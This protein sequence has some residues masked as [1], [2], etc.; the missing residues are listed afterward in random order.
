MLISCFSEKGPG[1]ISTGSLLH[2]SSGLVVIKLKHS[3][4]M[5]IMTGNTVTHNTGNVPKTSN[6]PRTEWSSNQAPVSY[7][8]ANH[9]FQFHVSL[10]S[11]IVTI[12]DFYQSV[13]LKK[14]CFVQCLFKLFPIVE[15]LI[16]SIAIHRVQRFPLEI[17]VFWKRLTKCEHD[18]KFSKTEGLL[19]LQ[20][21]LRN[22]ASACF[23]IIGSVWMDQANDWLEF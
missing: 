2:L 19:H 12:L 5:T 17:I 22:R 9:I 23:K 10:T 3:L 4:K 1:Y 15:E 8:V 13:N 6:T 16:V 14:L 20:K 7:S 11:S 21:Q 18:G